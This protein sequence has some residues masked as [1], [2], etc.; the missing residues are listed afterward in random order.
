MTLITNSAVLFPCSVASFL[1]L[2]VAVVLRSPLKLYKHSEARQL[3]LSNSFEHT[4][5][6]INFLV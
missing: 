3:T 4:H 6:Y 2:H 1:N 5:P